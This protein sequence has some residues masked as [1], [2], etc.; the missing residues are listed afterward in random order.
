MRWSHSIAV[1]SL[2]VL[3]SG[4][5]EILEELDHH[6]DGS[7]EFSYVVNMSSSKEKLS[8]MLSLDSMGG[9][10]IPKKSDIENKILEG[11]RILQS[12][13]GISRVAVLRDYEEFIFTIKFHYDSIQ[14]LNRAARIIHER[15]S[16][17]DVPF[18]PIFTTDPTGWTRIIDAH[19]EAFLAN[20][21][22]KN[23]SVLKESTYTTV[24][25]FDHPVSSPDK[26]V[27]LSG[28]KKA[29]MYTYQLSFLSVQPQI[30]QQHINLK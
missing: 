9:L 30:L 12:F 10:R 1:V 11:Q 25:R 16:P 20:L 6:P 23:A 26:D 8:A 28:S 17:Y 21:R 14:A 7:G 5:F 18:Q 22:K 2:L 15:M 29:L 13:P 4:C 27:R 19:T 3:S 24:Y